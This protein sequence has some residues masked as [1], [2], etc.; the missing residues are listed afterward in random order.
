MH[1]M[2]SP[3]PRFGSTSGITYI[4]P[5][6]SIEPF[7]LAINLSSI[8]NIKEMKGPIDNTNTYKKWYEFYM[9]VALN[10][11]ARSNKLWSSISINK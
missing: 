4:Y 10:I 6:N 9:F 5:R 1:G 7:K 8:L 2:K 11:F 3:P